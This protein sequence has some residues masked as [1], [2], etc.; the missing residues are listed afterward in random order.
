MKIEITESD[1]MNARTYVP[2][3]E[4]ESFVVDVY[5]SC[6]D[7]V[8][9]GTQDG[10]RVIP[11]PSIYKDNPSRKQRYLMGALA[12]L[13]LKKDFEPVEGTKFLMSADDY[14]RW[15]GSHVFNQLERL[16]TRGGDVR[17][18]IF[19]LISDY[20]ELEKRLNIEIYNLVQIQN[21]PCTR[22]FSMMM[23]Q[24]TSE[25][26]NAQVAELQKARDELASYIAKKKAGKTD[27]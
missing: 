14:D 20:R 26:L 7:K 4:K 27:A 8:E 9:L 12:A 19:D 2:M 24:S 25:Y 5:V 18:R 23:M 17:N 16:K 13:Y 10:E 11:M 21:D 6:L 3:L 22:I 1:I 15:A